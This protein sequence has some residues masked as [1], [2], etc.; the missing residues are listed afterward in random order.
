MHHIYMQMMLQTRIPSNI[1]RG[2]RTGSSPEGGGGGE[3]VE[4][5]YEYATAVRSEV[6]TEEWCHPCKTTHR[7]LMLM[8]NVTVARGEMSVCSVRKTRMSILNKP[9]FFALTNQFYS[10]RI[11]LFRT[12]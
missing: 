9:C 12:S 11:S 3:G 2:S 1:V 7:V 6:S 10:N 8:M 4:Q 5:R